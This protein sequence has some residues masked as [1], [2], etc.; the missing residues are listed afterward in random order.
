MYCMCYAASEYHEYVLY[1]YVLSTFALSA[2][3]F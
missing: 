1:R 2:I 3:A